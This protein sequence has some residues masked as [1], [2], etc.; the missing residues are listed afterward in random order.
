MYICRLYVF[1][2]IMKFKHILSFAVIAAGIFLLFGCKKSIQYVNY[3][4]TITALDSPYTLNEGGPTMPCFEVKIFADGKEIEDY[5]EFMA[6]CTFEAEG[7]TLSDPYYRTGKEGLAFAYFTPY[8]IDSF[9]GGSVT[10]TVTRLYR[11]SMVTYVFDGS[12]KATAEI[13]PATP[14]DEDSPVTGNLKKADDLAENTF[15]L[16]KQGGELQTFYWDKNRSYWDSSEDRINM[17]GYEGSTSDDAWLSA[18]C[19]PMSTIGK[20][21]ALNEEFLA[22]DER[23]LK[24]GFQRGS[25]YFTIYSGN[26]FNG[27]NVDMGD[28]FYKVRKAKPVKSD[29][30]DGNYVLIYY[31]SFYTNYNGGDEIQKHVCYGKCVFNPRK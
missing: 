4:V 1:N 28:S 29:E 31:V 13:L 5:E 30:W 24:I 21:I 2:Q 11:H 20:Q 22:A 15:V 23:G 27:S 10:A 25:V 8:D 12:A 9:E 16:Q 7:G 6:E 19:I 17:Y 26:S 3:E 14:E 18:A